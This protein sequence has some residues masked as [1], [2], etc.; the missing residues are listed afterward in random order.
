LAHG[1]DVICRRSSADDAFGVHDVAE[2]VAFDEEMVVSGTLLDF[3]DYRPRNRGNA[4]RLAAVEQMGTT[5]TMTEGRS[6]VYRCKADQ[7]SAFSR[8]SSGMEILMV[9]NP[10]ICTSYAISEQSRGNILSA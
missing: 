9:S 3:T 2:T 5:L 8:T 10:L 6:R 7:I 4:L 1:G